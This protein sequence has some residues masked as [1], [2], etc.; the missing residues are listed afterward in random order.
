M[1]GPDLERKGRENMIAESL[2]RHDA[3]FKAMAGQLSRRK[4]GPQAS[5]GRNTV[6]LFPGC[7]M[8]FVQC[9][10]GSFTMGHE[11]GNGPFRRREVTISRSF[12]MA[13]E[14]MTFEAW[15]KYLKATGRVVPEEQRI[16]ARKRGGERCALCGLSDEDWNG[17]LQW[18]NDRHASEFKGYVLRL[19]TEAEWE[20]AYRAG[21]SRQDDPF[22]W[23]V[24][25]AGRQA[26]ASVPFSYTEDE[27][28][29]DFLKFGHGNVAET[30]WDAYTMDWQRKALVAPGQV[31]TKK[32]NSWGLKDMIGNGREWVLDRFCCAA[33][34]F[35]AET[36]ACQPKETDPLF[37]CELVKW[38]CQMCRGGDDGYA[39]RKCWDDNG[40]DWNEDVWYPKQLFCY[41]LVIGPDLIREKRKKAM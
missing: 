37:G 15:F 28:R 4:H 35:P 8:E 40:S 31:G 27:R 2:S 25:F 24:P 29:Q 41:R 32:G 30:S 22:A 1:V 38:D 3:C 36:Y 16:E 9:P 39:G 21:A 18:L 26:V 10:P 7:S 33:G 19:P 17:F 11:A 12:Y 23:T 13:T 14:R 20:Y 5:L 6:T 34:K